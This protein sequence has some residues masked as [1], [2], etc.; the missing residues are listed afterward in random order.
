MKPNLLDM[1]SIQRAIWRATPATLPNDNS[2]LNKFYIQGKQ[3]AMAALQPIMEGEIDM[4]W[5]LTYKEKPR[6]EDPVLVLASYFLYLT[7]FYE[8]GTIKYEDSDASWI[9]DN[10]DEFIPEGWYMKVPVNNIFDGDYNIISIPSPDYWME[11]PLPQDVG[12]I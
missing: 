12:G 4:A 2:I 5:K 6:V 7:A 9:D 1:K 10:G 8:D 11:L 3:D